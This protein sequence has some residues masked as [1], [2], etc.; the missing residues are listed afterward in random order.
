MHVRQVQVEQDDVVIIQLA[1]IQTFLAEV[2]RIDI[3]AFGGEHQLD[4]LGGGRF[5]FDQQNAHLS[6]P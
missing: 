6:P 3:E 4:G 5:V 1:E 2:G